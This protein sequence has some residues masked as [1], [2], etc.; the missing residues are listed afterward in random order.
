M[1]GFGSGRPAGGGRPAVDHCRSIDVNRFNKEGILADGWSGRWEWKR[2]G[3]RIALI[4]IRG[5]RCQVRLVYRCKHGGG[6]WEDVDQPIPIFWK[7][8]RFGGERPFFQCPGVVGGKHCGRAV[9]KLY[10]AGRYFLCRHCYRLTYASRKE[11]R[12][13][14][15]LRRAN[16]I[17]VELGGEPDTASAFPAR[18]KGMWRRTYERLRRE[19]MGAEMRAD[20]ELAAFTARLLKVDQRQPR[21][22]GRKQGGF[23]R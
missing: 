1:G 16:R 3:E 11:G 14:R 7:P 6:D 22:L 23:W 5:G 2:D 15:A 21:R 12:F 4:G 18:P 9:L 13:D 8:C 10:G 20:E 19:I 17:R